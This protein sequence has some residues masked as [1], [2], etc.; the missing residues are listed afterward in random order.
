RAANA[1]PDPTALAQSGPTAAETGTTNSGYYTGLRINGLPLIQ[2]GGANQGALGDIL[3]IGAADVLS[4]SGVVS[5]PV[6]ISGT[7]APGNSP[8]L[9]Q[10]GPQTWLAGAVPYEWEINDVLGGEGNNPGWDFQKVTGGVTIISTP[11]SKATI[12][13]KSLQLNNTPGNVSNFNPANA[14]TWRILSTTTGISGFSRSVI[15]LDTTGFTNAMGPGALLVDISADGR[16]LLLRFVPTLPYLSF[17]QPVWTS[18]GPTYITGNENSILAPNDPASGA[19]Q[20]IAVH[21]TNPNVAWIGAVNGGIWMTTNLN[22]ST[23]NNIN[24]DNLG[25]VDDPAETPTWTAIGQNLPSI[26]IAGLA[27]SP[28]DPSGAAVTNATPLNQIILYAGTGSFSSSAQGGTAAGLFRSLDGGTTWT[29]IGNFEGLR[30][31]SIVPSSQTA[32]LVYVGTYE[33]SPSGQFGAGR[34]G[35]YRSLDKGDTWS[36]LSGQGGLP[37]FHV[38]DIVQEPGNA[39]RFYVAL[40]GAANGLNAANIGIY[41]TNN[42]ASGVVTWTAV[43]TGIAPDY[44]HDGVAGEAQLNEDLNG[45]SMFDP[46]EDANDNG[47]LDLGEDTN[48]NGV[49]DE[50]ELDFDGNGAPNVIAIAENLLNA[51]RIRLS[52]SEAAGHAVYAAVIGAHDGRLAGVFRSANA[53]A[54]W[55]RLGAEPRTNSG[56]GTRHFGI[57]ADPTDNTTVYIAGDASTEKPYAGVIYRWDS[58]LNQWTRI[59]AKSR[60]DPGPYG[61]TAPHADIRNLAFD[62]GNNGF[63]AITDGGVYRLQN[64]RIG[65]GTSWE[66]IA[67]SVDAAEISSLT[68][69]RNTNTVFV[70]IQDN[71]VIAQRPGTTDGYGLLDGDGNYVGVAYINPLVPA[72]GQSMRFYMGNNFNRFYRESFNSADVSQGFTHLL[73]KAPNDPANF[74]GLD[75]SWILDDVTDREF[76]GFQPIPFAVNAVDD[77]SDGRVKLLM[78]RLGLYT[79]DDNGDHIVVVPGWDFASQTGYVSAVAYGGRLGGVAD[80]NIIYA[81]RGDKG[82]ILFSSDNGGKFQS[83]SPLGAGQIHQITLDPQNWR[84]AF[85]VDDKHVWVITVAANGTLS[86]VDVTGNLGDI[87]G[88]F[89]SVEVA[90]LNG[91]VVVLVGTRDGVYRLGVG[92]VT[93]LKANPTSYSLWSRFGVGLPNAQVADLHF[94][95]VDNV[96][97][98]GTRGRGAWLLTNAASALLAESVLRFDANT[99]NQQVRLVLATATAAAPRELEFFYGGSLIATYPLTSILRIAVHLGQGTDSLIVD[100]SEGQVAIPA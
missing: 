61:G 26:A 71:G 75:D 82:E 11:A 19:V 63:M 48:S 30:T 47:I 53:G 59:S 10:T 67:R 91:Q 95:P 34:G 58:G 45:N 80:Q 73:L 88:G 60:P 56:Q 8:G 90:N 39:G 81:A 68:Y 64:P 42:G 96:L 74:S 62:T 13:V 57:A 9:L 97:V 16:D 14:Y 89:Q 23:T 49:L 33:V 6:V 66:F 46:G 93:A 86:S 100:S 69:D 78:G 72:P 25:G 79:S 28:Y 98:A 92:D 40:A 51:I 32:G 77:L 17:N 76:A 7:I 12:R 36:R 83:L 99:G 24:D 22:W 18:Q 44:D 5:G 43:V 3:R 1:P 15:N 87:T 55:S 29:R 50:G 85:A 37:E 38:T 52:V 70:G 54:T 65:G 41:R 2:A 35:V 20:A 21:P 27:V 94:D 31:T 4:G 84:T